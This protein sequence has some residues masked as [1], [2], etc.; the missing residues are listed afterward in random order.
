MIESAAISNRALALPSRSQQGIALAVCLPVL[1]VLSMIGLAAYA[2]AI[3]ELQMAANVEC[4]E[5]AFQAAEFAIEQALLADDLSVAYTHA[6]PKV[7][8]AQVTA[9]GTPAAPRD[10]YSYRLYF[11]GAQ[12]LQG[13]QGPVGTSLVA[14]HFVIE[15]TGKSVRGAQDLHVQGFY[16]TRA[17]GWTADDVEAGCPDETRSCGPS[18]DAAPRRTF[19]LQPGSE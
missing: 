16:V 15:A 2:A 12:S 19:W 11:T 1:V 8:A 6:A 10:E 9:T 14:F 7:V 4:Q 3:V 13:T 18:G 5:R 17:L